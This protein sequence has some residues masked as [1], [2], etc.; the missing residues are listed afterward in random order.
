MSPQ[1]WLA[2]DP[3]AHRPRV[4]DLPLRIVRFSGPALR[5][6]VEHH[7]I[8]GVAVPIYSPAK[9]VAD[10]FKYRHKLGLDVA[11]EALEECRR[12]RKCSNDDLWRFAKICRVERVMRPYMEA[13]R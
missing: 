6:G 9:T 5:E 8:D 7:V 3:K 1:V 4:A 12:A 2:I 10:C 11:L 13:I